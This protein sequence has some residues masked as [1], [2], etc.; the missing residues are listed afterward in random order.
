MLSFDAYSSA[1][2]QPLPILKKNQVCFEKPIV[3]Y[4]KKPSFRTYLRNITIS[5]AF[6]SKLA[7]TKF[8]RSEHRTL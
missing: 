6:Y 1:Y 7:V 4:L 2:F 5:A 8:S 3:F